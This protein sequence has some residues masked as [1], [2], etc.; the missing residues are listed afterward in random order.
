NST[1]FAPFVPLEIKGDILSPSYP[2]KEALTASDAKVQQKAKDDRE[3]YK[4]IFRGVLDGFIQWGRDNKCAS[5]ETE[6]GL[7]LLRN[8]FFMEDYAGKQPPFYFEAVLQNLQKVLL[9][10]CNEQN[11]REK[12][13]DIY[14]DLCIQIA[15][16]GPG[17]Y[18]KLEEYYFLLCKETSLT[19]WLA[20][21]RTNI[22]KEYA[23]RY[24]KDHKISG[25]M[26]V[27]SVNF[28]ST[29]AM[30]ENWN[31]IFTA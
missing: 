21:Y 13:I 29:A 4:T 6:N 23:A 31:P 19:Y 28:F 10:L 11:S 12:R 16:C 22:I 9:A 5:A 15:V 14:R 24:N 25:G 27:H 1:A 7:A 18:T 3:L 20:E 17:M 8:Q 30:E 26:S 2:K